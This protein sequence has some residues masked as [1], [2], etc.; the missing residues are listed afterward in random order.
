MRKKSLKLASIAITILLV[1]SASSMMFV[2]GAAATSPFLPEPKDID[3]DVKT[4]AIDASEAIEPLTAT[5]HSYWNLSDVAIWTGYNGLTGTIFLTYYTLSYIGT[6]VEI[7]VQSNT[8]FPLGDLR[9]APDTGMP[10]KPTDAMLEYIADQFED[11]IL[12]KESEFFGAPLFHNGSNAQLQY[13]VPAI[14]DDPEYY[15]E[16]TGR[17]VILVCN[18]RDENYYNASYPY[19][20]IG[21]HIGAYESYYYDRNIITLDAVTWHHGLGPAGT[22]WGPHFDYVTQT[23]HS[24]PVPVASQ[25]A[26]DSTVAH[27][28]QHLLHY[29]LA[30]GDVTFMNEGCSMYAEFLCGYGI[31]PDYPNSYFATPDNSLTEW[32]DQGDINILA[33]YG[34][35]ALWCLYLADR[36]GP[37]FLRLYFRLNAYGVHG[38]EAID[39]ALYFSHYNERF[40]EVYRDW[41]LANLIRADSPGAGKYNYKSINLNDPAY[42]PVRLYEIY[43][44]PVPPTRGTDFGN[45][46]TIL[47]YDTGVSA[48][49]GWGS[50]YIALR[51]WERPSFV[52]FDGDE[53]TLPKQSKWTLTDDGWYSGTGEDLVTYL[54]AGNAYVDSTNPTLTIVTAY[55]LETL[56]DYGFVQV[57]TDGGM[58]WTSLENEYTTSDHDPAAHPDIVAN[59]PGLTDYNPDWSDWTTMDF[60]LSAYAG[61]T[62]MIGFRYMTDWAVT[63]EGWWINSATVSGT[64]LTLE[65]KDIQFK[66]SFQVTVVYALELPRGRILYLPFDMRLKDTTQTGFAMAFAKFPSYV[67]LIVTPTMPAGFADYQFQVNRQPFSWCVR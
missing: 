9:N 35:A 48:I 38:I 61:Q 60:D 45:T 40:P 11:N 10:T 22:E 58:T 57:S 31:D 49:C 19:R 20:I 12:P 26:Y 28:W 54:L 64:V 33:D 27:E 55:G 65:N 59:L 32:G 1:I 47:G 42:I 4:A 37:E 8:R 21:V 30:A 16:E 41:K 7:W 56:W 39:Y 5:H 66:A 14:P 53:F 2:N 3:E 13:L 43:G 63:Y 23:Y 50:D 24:H 52:Y 29:E 18:I 15:Y 46:I 34:A 25:Y 36:Y 62:V 51:D 67:I 6:D 44:Q 17:A